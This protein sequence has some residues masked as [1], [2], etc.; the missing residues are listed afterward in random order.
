M[1]FRT[2]SRDSIRRTV[3]KGDVVFP[4]RVIWESSGFMETRDIVIKGARVHNLK[5]VNLTLPRNQLICFTGVSGSG[6]SSL[7]FDTIFAEGQRR[8]IESLSAYA[9]Q[10]LGQIR[11]PDVDQITGLSPTV[12]F[13]QKAAARNPRSTVGTMTEIYDYLRVLYARVGVPHCVSCGTPIG[14]QTRDGIVDRIM[15]LGVGTRINVMA[16]IVRGRKGEYLDLFADLQR[17]GYLRVRVDGRIVQLTETQR[18]ERQIR[19]DI[20]LVVDRLVVRVDGHGR[21]GEAVD[22]ALGFGN[23][24]LIVGFEDG[25]DL[26][27]SS[28]LSCTLCGLSASEPTPQLF[29]FNNPQG[30]CPTCRGLGT[31]FALDRKRS[32]PDDSL[33]VMDGA[34]A[35]L[36]EPR[37]RWK[38]HYYNGVLER[39]GADV[40]TPWREISQTAREELLY[41]VKNRIRLEWRRR[42]GGVYSHSDTFE[43]ILPP[44]ERRYAEATSP[45]WRGRLGPYMRT[46]RCPKCLGARLRAEAVAVTIEGMSLPAAAAM[47]VADALA[48]LDGLKLTATRRMIAEDALKEILGRL[49]FLL[50]VGLDYLTLD[51]AA[52]TLSGGEAQRIRLARQIGSGLVGVTYVLDEPSI[53]LHQRDNKSLLDALCLL[54]E[55]GNTIIVV[56]HDEETMKR[57]DWIVDFGPGPGH[58]GGEVVA[59]GDWRKIALSARSRTGA[60]LSGRQS[61]AVPDRRAPTGRR[62]GVYGA[63]QNNLKGIDVELPLGVFNC[64]T[65][66]SGSGKS[67]LVND[68]VYRTLARELNRAESEPGDFDRIE[69]I[70]ALDKVIEIDQQPI[71]RTPRSNPATYTGVF[72]PIRA[73]YA[74]LPESRVRGYRPGRFSFNVK[75]GRCEA[76]GGNGANVVEMDFLADVW[77][78]CAICEGRR[79]SRETLDVCYKEAS[80]AD[81]LDMEVKRAC[82]FFEAVPQ[83]HRILKVLVEVGMSY[84]KLGQPAPT[85]SGGEAQRVKLAKELCRKQTGATLY[86]LD[87]PTTGLHFADIQNLLSVLHRLVDLG[88]TV[89]VIEH[90]MDVIKTADWVIDLGPGGG[91]SGGRV[92]AQG[93]P[94]RVAR[95]RRSFTARPLRSALKHGHDPVG[96]DGAR[97]RRSGGKGLIREI[98]VTGARENNLRNVD[99]R[100]PREK[101]TVVS[102]VSG[103]G[104]SSLALDTVFA[105]GQRR[106]VESLSAYARQF[107]GQLPKPKVERVVGLSPAIAIEQK[108]ASKN[109]RSTVGTVTEV[110]DYLRALFALVGEVYCPVCDVRAG[111][112]AIQEIVE[113]I[114]RMP[115]GRRVYLLSPQ[116]PGKGEDYDALISRAARDG[117]LRGRLD[118]EVFDLKSPAEIDHRQSHRLE[119]LV[120]R[121]TL[122]PG[123]RKRIADSIEKALMLSGGV[124]IA[125]SPDDGRETRFS[126]VLSCPKCGRSFDEVAPQHLSFNSHEG[127]CPSCEGLGTQKG[128]GKNTLIP[129]HRKS[130]SEGAVPVLGELKD[131]PLAAL[132]RAVGDAGEFDLEMPI[133]DMSQTAQE[134]LLYGTGE[135]WIQDAN[136]LRFKYKGLFNSLEELVRGSPRFR[137]KMGDLVEDVACLVCRGARLKPESAAVRLRGM[138][139]F[140]LVDLPIGKARR[141]FEDLVLT[142]RELVAV[143][144]VLQEIRVR[145]RFLHEVGLG[146]LSLSRRA[147]TLSGGE[148]QRIRLASQ[149]G[150]GLTGVLY[151]L[152]E[153]T[154]G[155]HQRDNRR[156]LAALGQLRDLGNT[157]LVV[158]HDRETLEAAD[159]ILDFGPGAGA[160]G[161]ALVAEGPPNLLSS[162]NGSLTAKYLAGRLAVESPPRRSAQ[163]GCVEVVGARHN[164]LK[165]LNVKFPLGKLIGVTGVSGSGKSSLVNDVLYGALAARMNGV[166]GTAAD[167]DE[168]RGMDGIDKVINID[169]SPIGFSSRSNPATYVKVFDRV[170]RL[171]AQLPDARI[172]GFSPGHFSFN[173]RKGRCEACKG[174]GSRCIEMHFL[175]DVWVTCEDCNGKR[176]NRDVVNVL[177]KGRS[178]ADVLDMTVDEALRQFGNVPGIHRTLK[179]LVEVGLEYIKMGQASTTLSGGEAQRV[180]LARELARP[181]TGKTVYLLDEPTTGLHIA[182]VARLLVVLNRLVDAGNTVIVIEHNL[183]VIKTADWIIDLGP[184]GGDE[185]GYLV[186]A[187]TPEEVAQVDASYTGR[188]LREMLDRDDPVMQHSPQVPA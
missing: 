7:A 93:T 155:L 15:A 18:L 68:I 130:V 115:S 8:Y 137:E 73:L 129:D 35:P 175:P 62:L 154:I 163:R 172:R 108:A 150:S 92:V 77:V 151:V 96:S 171:Y 182:D 156:L 95:S 76:C 19:H 26:L 51:R 64:V 119:I 99:V 55:A 181:N 123:V 183:D 164:N 45:A 85:L 25:E 106:Y 169:Q 165:G 179:T 12:S 36:G 83:I 17:E 91:E 116:R 121:V 94:E 71:G 101:L 54:R 161:G 147:P 4:R 152:D 9:R 16:P 168:V 139:I 6:K 149:I 133:L 138:T 104:K 24:T 61:I 78:T 124:V 98:Q 105:E 174:L 49:R 88:N 74:D 143:G 110:Y 14:T 38:I 134:V 111:A 145:M 113:R 125:A 103:S 3:N 127:W 107:L 30:M 126:Q 21:I 142:E 132:I 160:H 90:N 141:W 84:V 173:H 128:M 146:Y 118:G 100:I 187:G 10:F 153:P 41:G 65:G 80:I 170:R 120:D 32:V 1:S 177:Y 44:L 117:Y 23:G 52:P 148:A 180:K 112:L 63:R 166:R 162:E 69:G 43:G 57:A 59:F 31:Q 114:L 188:F 75:G 5:D 82:A 67:S 158:E 184:E 72:D 136:G 79:F 97:S 13:E 89:V 159:H 28:N 37:N 58:L 20:D 86:I 70:D 56:E 81:V 50:D 22:A 186:A 53:G 140:E 60:Y 185:G 87:E 135:R 48:F 42:D 40:S 29:S 27:L 176:Y 47:S 34:I 33:S 11:K 2:A 157:L 39:H 109:P 122:K 144:E 66:V 167:H 131:G 102:G 178:V 46:G